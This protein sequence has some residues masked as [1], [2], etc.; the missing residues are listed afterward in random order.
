MEKKVA[1][2]TGA[3]S[4]IGRA[5]A[6]ELARNNCFVFVHYFK[7]QNGA[8]R[9]KTLINDFG[10]EAEIVQADITK[11]IEI[12]EMFIYLGKKVKRVDVLVNNAGLYIPD[13]IEKMAVSTWDM[14]NN[15]NVRG[16]YLCSRYALGLLKTSKNPKIINIASRSGIVPMEE[17]AAYCTAAAG[18]IMLSKVMALEF[19][20]Y[21][22]KVNSISPG[23]TPTPMTEKYDTEEDFREYAKNNPSGRIGSPED[24]AGV[25]SFMISEEA[26]FINGENINV[27]GGILLK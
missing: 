10:G 20:K 18:I 16:K 19:S 9:T 13:Y 23:L 5:I 1:I 21:G 27:S 15:V 25:V 4:G 7:N 8:K 3:S 22:I 12:K 2:V 26:N 14:I 17:S 24:I 11:E 6:L